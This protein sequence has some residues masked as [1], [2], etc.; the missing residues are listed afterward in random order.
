M[1]YGIFGDVHSNREAFQ[2]VIEEYKK[3]DIANFI[4]VG[5]IV[6]YGADPHWCIEE[7][8]KIKA[9]IVG[10]NHDWA[11]AG[12]FS[13][14][15]FNYA[16]REAVRWTQGI[17]TDGEKEFLGSLDLVIN[18]KD[19][20][21][22]HGSLDSPDFFY[23]IIDEKSAYRCFR[24]MKE[25]NLCFVGHS[26]VPVVF[27]M[28]NDGIKYTYRNLIELKKDVKYIVNVGSVGQPRDGNPSAAFSIYDSDRMTVEI[29]RVD[30]DIE[31]AA[32]KILKAGLP[33]FLGHRLLEGR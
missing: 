27:S 22:V 4:C 6:G 9:E 1:R 32:N 31:S 5:D 26:H 29:K 24:N 12:R 23:Y 30:Y 3:E 28:G 16:A 11:S 20:S 17:L 8:Q 13:T 19:F 10:G 14:G 18:E 7:V 25:R 15:Y 33:E 2:K 21:V